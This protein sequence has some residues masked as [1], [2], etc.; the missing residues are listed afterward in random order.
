VIDTA[1][2]YD[3]IRYI[4]HVLGP[5]IEEVKI[6]TKKV[7]DP[8]LRGTKQS[9]KIK[10]KKK[11]LKKMNFFDPPMIMLQKSK[12]TETDYHYLCRTTTRDCSLNLT[13]SGAEI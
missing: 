5:R 8:S 1:G 12:F 9:S 13:L 10:V 2:N 3:E 7:K 4:I 6:K 11:K